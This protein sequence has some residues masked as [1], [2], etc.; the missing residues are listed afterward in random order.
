MELRG[1]TFR[2]HHGCQEHEKLYG[3]MFEVDFKAP[4]SL[5]RAAGSD[6]LSDAADYGIIY[7]IIKKEM[8]IPSELLESVA[9]RI[10]SAVRQEFPYVFGKIEIRI[11]KLDPP[12]GGPC[13]AAAITV[14]DTPDQ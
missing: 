11:S 4:Y 13:R 9:A 3:G 6:D 7:E 1:M 10:A 14:F 8:Q 12:V 5:G 2:A